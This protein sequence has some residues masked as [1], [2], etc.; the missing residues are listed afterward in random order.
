MMNKKVNILPNLF[1]AGNLCC[2]MVSLVLSSLGIFVAAAWLI[3][4]GLLL[5][6]FDGK[7][8]R[9]T[10]KVTRFGKEL[11][12]LADL[13]TF[14]A[15]P[16]LLVF[17]RFFDPSE[18]KGILLACF[19]VT[20]GALRLARFNTQQPGH[21]RI[22][23][24]LPIPA[25]A[26]LL[27]GYVLMAGSN[28]QNSIF[29]AAFDSPMLRY[30]ILAIPAVGLLMVSNI[31][32][33]KYQIF[34]VPKKNSFILLFLLVALVL[35]AFS[36]HAHFIFLASAVFYAVL[37]PAHAILRRRREL[38]R[39]FEEN[40]DLVAEA[41]QAQFTPS[42]NRGSKRPRTRYPGRKRFRRRS[43]PR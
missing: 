22:F 19:Y 4:L 37:G 31:R 1:T 10:N 8:A 16:A 2:G 14:G 30:P 42:A 3:F 17:L 33:P 18:E 26:A 23:V 24:G 41:V 6:L 35:L 21:G 32:Y 39:R 43:G 29:G 25:A 38:Q 5:D 20:C 13:L 28:P 36:I 7:V 34:E 27:G 15:A 9:M 12:S 11:D 40:P